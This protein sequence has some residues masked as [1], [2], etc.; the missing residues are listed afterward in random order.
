MMRATGI[1]ATIEAAAHGL[2]GT[3]GGILNSFIGISK[4]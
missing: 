4:L 2:F 3:V 1:L